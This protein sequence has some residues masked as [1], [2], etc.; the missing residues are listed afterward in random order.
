MAA[1]HPGDRIAKFAMCPNRLVAAVLCLTVAVPPGAF[2]QAVSAAPTA[3]ASTTSN[4]SLTAKPL[5]DFAP[6]PAPF[7]LTDAPTSLSPTAI[8]TNVF[9]LYGGAETRFANRP[10][11]KT[12]LQAS[13]NALQL[14]DLGDGSGG[15]LT[16]Q[17]ERRL[18]ERLMRD[19]RRE[20][21][22][23]DD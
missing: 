17:T 22:Y 9:G 6:A 19:L 15:K 16:P 10:G 13:M 20:P 18:G 11:K 8:D 2:A 12:G 21:D 7:P 3:N 4:T 1:R 5:A 14:P 23:L